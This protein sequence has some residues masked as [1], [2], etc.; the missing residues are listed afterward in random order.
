MVFRYDEGTFALSAD[1][2]V[3]LSDTENVLQML[4]RWRDIMLKL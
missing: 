4:I 1:K 3:G 2:N